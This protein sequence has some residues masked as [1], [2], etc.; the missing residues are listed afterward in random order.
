MLAAVWT[1]FCF[2]P[3]SQ[4]AASGEQVTWTNQ[5]AFAPHHIVRCTPSACAGKSG[6]TGGDSWAGSGVLNPGATYSHTFTGTGTYVYYCSI[7]G[8]AAMHGTITVA[9]PAP[10]V[11]EPKSGRWPDRGRQH[12]GDPRLGVRVRCE[13]EVRHHALDVGHVRVQR[14]AEGAR[15]NAR[16]RGG[17]G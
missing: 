17:W 16:L 12:G 6:G 7:H 14:R 10:K 11:T 1:E 15:P 3:P 13:R 9:S 5:S 4:K 2:N 8:Y